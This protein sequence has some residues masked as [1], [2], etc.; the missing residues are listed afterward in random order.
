M[1]RRILL[2][3]VAFSLFAFAGLFIRVVFPPAFPPGNS[4]QQITDLVLLV[5]PT[6]FLEIERPVNSQTQLTLTIYNVVFFA[7][8]GL[9]LA[10]IARRPRV[11]LIAYIATCLLLAAVEAWASGYALAYFSWSA[12]GVALFL[13]ALPFWALARMVHTDTTISAPSP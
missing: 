6:S 13:Y 12:L 5:W 10:V 2:S 11:V 1:R 8:L 3:I 4:K 9:L 7:A